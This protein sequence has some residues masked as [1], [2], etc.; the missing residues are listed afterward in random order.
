[1]EEGEEGEGA[2]ALGAALSKC[3][4]LQCCPMGSCA[5]LPALS[6]PL[7]PG[8]SSCSS[9]LRCPWLSRLCEELLFI[10]CNM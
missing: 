3:P 4:P 6:W 8:G 10:V 1:M 9:P 5:M 2:P 7:L